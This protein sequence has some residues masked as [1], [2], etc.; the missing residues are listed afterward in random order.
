M[1]N[2][3]IP[4]S[5]SEGA[6]IASGFRGISESGDVCVFQ[7]GFLVA[8]IVE[9]FVEPPAL[10]SSSSPP[11]PPPSPRLQ[12]SSACLPPLPCLVLFHGWV[13]VFEGYS[14]VLTVLVFFK[15][16]P[17]GDVLVGLFHVEMSV[18]VPMVDCSK[19]VKSV[20]IVWFL[21]ASL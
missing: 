6:L 17:N 12:L 9:G 4:V 19:G 3:V 21:C 1:A 18:S 13:F 20:D 5:I 14:A 16:G 15:E 10:P 8:L 7:K 2:D 11:A